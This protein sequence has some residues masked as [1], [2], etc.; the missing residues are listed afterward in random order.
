MR[1]TR[2]SRKM[3]T[4]PK[5]LAAECEC[6]QGIFNNNNNYYLLLCDDN[7]QPP[8]SSIHHFL[9]GIRKLTRWPAHIHIY[10][11]V[12]EDVEGKSDGNDDHV[13]NVPSEA[14]EGDTKGPHFDH[15]FEHKQRQDAD[16]QTVTDVD[17]Q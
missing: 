5:P 9:I 1:A 12:H 16:R 15:R 8:A 11:Y 10:T 14:K 3:M 13:K 7:E 4:K 6:C 2:H 17:N